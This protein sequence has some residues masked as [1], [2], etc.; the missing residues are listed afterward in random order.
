[1]WRDA[2]LPGSIQL[3]D[4][5][6][7]QLPPTSARLL[8]QAPLGGPNGAHH[9][10]ASMLVPANERAVLP[11]HMYLSLGCIYR[12][13]Q[14]GTSSRPERKKRP[15]CI[16]SSHLMAVTIRPLPCN[17]GFSGI[18]FSNKNGTI[19]SQRETCPHVSSAGSQL[20]IVWGCGGPAWRKRRGRFFRSGRTRMR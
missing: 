16:F 20:C 14:N 4:S 1:M 18:A 11:G 5:V 7:C 3:Q 10:G 19:F 12:C 15:L 17:V 8:A 6:A 2:A 13:G 9:G